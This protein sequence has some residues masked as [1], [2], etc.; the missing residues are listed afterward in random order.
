MMSIQGQ[1]EAEA[2]WRGGPASR[3]EEHLEAGLSQ[4]LTHGETASTGPLAWRHL[5]NKE[6][7]EFSVDSEVI[8]AWGKQPEQSRGCRLHSGSTLPNQCKW[9]AEKS[10]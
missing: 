9:S 6:R 7:D 5:A 1:E 4:K 3:S 8:Q 10:G 2:S